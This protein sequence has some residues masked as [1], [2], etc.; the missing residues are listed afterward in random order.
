MPSTSI[1]NFV[2][3]CSGTMSANATSSVVALG[4]I[5]TGSDV[6]IWNSGPNKAFFVLGDA[7]NLTAT[8]PTSTMLPNGHWLAPL[9]VLMTQR[10]VN[11]YLAAICAASESATIF[12]TVGRGS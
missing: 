5:T 11:G 1:D 10:G 6:A 9:S 12:I 2:P 8:L 3:C 4:P 7:S